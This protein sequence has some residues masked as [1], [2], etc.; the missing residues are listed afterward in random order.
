MKNSIILIMF[1][2]LFIEVSAQKPLDLDKY[3]AKH[4]TVLIDSKIF[5]KKREIKIFYPDEYFT[6]PKRKFKVLY[7]FDS[8]NIRTFNFVSGTIQ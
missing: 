4:K 5:K 6:E 2:F 7:L 1:S 8:Q 3:Y